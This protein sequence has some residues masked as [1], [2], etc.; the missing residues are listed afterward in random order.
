MLYYPNAGKR[1]LVPLVP[2]TDEDVSAY[3]LSTRYECEVVPKPRANR[4]SAY[5]VRLLPAS[6]AFE[7]TTIETSDHEIWPIFFTSA[8]TILVDN[9]EIRR[10]GD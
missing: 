8:S 2:P 3:T 1:V 5:E 10:L 4:G 9:V 6:P 7:R